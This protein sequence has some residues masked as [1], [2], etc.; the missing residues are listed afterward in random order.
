MCIGKRSICRNRFF[1]KIHKLVFGVSSIVSAFS[2]VGY[3]VRVEPIPSI[4]VSNPSPTINA[5]SQDLL[6]ALGVIGAS[7][8]DILEFK[9]TGKPTY[10]IVQA[11]IAYDNNSSNSVYQNLS[12]AQDDALVLFSFVLHNDKK[13]S[14]QSLKT[15]MR[16]EKLRMGMNSTEIDRLEELSN[17]LI[18]DSSYILS[19]DE[20]TKIQNLVPIINDDP[21]AFADVI[22]PLIGAVIYTTEHGPVTPDPSIEQGLAEAAQT[23]TGLSDEQVNNIVNITNNY[24]ET[25]TFTPSQEDVN[26]MNQAIAV[27]AL[28]LGAFALYPLLGYTTVTEVDAITRGYD[29]Y[30]NEAEAAYWNNAAVREGYYNDATAAAQNRQNYRQSAANN[31]AQTRENTV[32]QRQSDVN[33]AAQNRQS[34][35]DQRQSD[36]NSAA[37]NRQ[38]NVNQRQSDANNAAENRQGDVSQRQSNANSAAQSRQNGA[39]GRRPSLN[40]DNSGSRGNFGSNGGRSNRS[41]SGA[42]SR[43]GGRR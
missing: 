29:Y 26:D 25:N 37:Q 16:D 6:D 3:E 22:G 14:D 10:G 21:F 27:A 32:D 24:M 17:A 41:R 34:T 12:Q 23:L 42:G 30:F 31:A 39:Q 19:S 28:P 5:P 11:V 4:R 40:R 13:I 38:G 15:L 1:M 8:S 7:T 43:S 20:L 33:N 2:I 18:S 9:Q 35:V 36:A